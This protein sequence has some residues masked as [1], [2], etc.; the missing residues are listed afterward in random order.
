[1]RVK[2][3][4][5]LLISGTLLIGG[6]TGVAVA[7]DFTDDTTLTLN[8]TDRHIDRGDEVGFS[9]HLIADH[10]TCRNH[11]SIKLFRNGDKVAQTQTNTHGFY[12]FHRTIFRTATWQTRFGG[13]VG[14]THPHNHT[15]LKSGSRRITIYVDE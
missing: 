7:H 1:M 13:S 6:P 12:S 14:G 15:C 5:A 9:G 10:A 8:V 3:I 2:S 11:R 4:L